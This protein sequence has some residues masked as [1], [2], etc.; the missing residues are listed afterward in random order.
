MNRIHDWYCK[1]D[2]WN[3]LMVRGVLPEVLEGVALD[4]AVLE[5]GPGPGLVSKA[6]LAYGVE[7][8][9]SVE[10]DDAAADRLREQFGDSVTV[11][12][13]DASAMPMEANQFDTIVCCT[14][15]HHVPTVELQD[16]ILREAHRV[17]K[18]GGTFTGSDSKTDLRFR[19][20]HLFDIHNPVDVDGFEDRLLAAGFAEASVVSL[21]GRFV[22]RASK[23]A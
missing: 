16:T 13:G 1:S 19:I 23:A 8:L 21:N 4:G 11:H 20:F 22:F 5:I 9:T 2:R 18:P 7:Q 17:L 14:M 3:D 12:T 6:L 15:L 10:I